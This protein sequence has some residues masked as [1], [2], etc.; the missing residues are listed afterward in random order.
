MGAFLAA[1]QDTFNT[2]VLIFS[3]ITTVFL[4][5]LSNLANDYGDSIHGADS[6]ERKGPLRA[7][8][9]GLIS[10]REMKIAII[11]SVIL[12]LMSGLYLLYISLGFNTR[13]FLL[14]FLLGLVAIAAAITYTAGARPYG[15]AGFGDV[16]VMIFFGVVGVLGSFYLHSQGRISADLILPALSCGFFS[17]AVL[18]VNNIRDIESDKA[19]GKRS[20][21]VR[22]GRSSAVI[23]H[24]GLLISGWLCAIIFTISNYN[25]PLQLIFLISMPFFIKNAIGIYKHKSAKDLDPYLRQLAASTLVFVLLF[26][27]GLFLS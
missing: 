18:N 13:L 10:K 26:G 25:S 11:I 15:Y 2:E 9:S 1:Y 24:W 7:V 4:Q 12:S 8:Q 22:V 20:I 27:I 19:A 17:V 3:A 14:F 23:Y 16:S 21:P 5:I 6:S